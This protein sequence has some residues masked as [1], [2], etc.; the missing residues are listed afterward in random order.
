MT[1]SDSRIPPP[2]VPPLEAEGIRYEQVMDTT[3]I[4]TEDHRG[5]MRA[6]RIEDGTVL[7]TSKVYTVKP[8]IE[9]GSD[10]GDVYFKQMEFA[11]DGGSI[12]VTNEDG[13]RFEVKIVSGESTPLEE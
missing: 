9:F 6:T 4:D 11:P 7:W 10:G 12:L 1:F 8:I 2:H 13:N 3:G 5:W